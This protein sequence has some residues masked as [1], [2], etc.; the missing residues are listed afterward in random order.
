MNGAK[1]NYT[2]DQQDLDFSQRASAAAMVK[3]LLSA[4]GLDAVA[5]GFGVTQISSDNHTWV[6]SRLA[7]EFAQMPK[8]GDRL[9][10][11]TWVSDA[12][13]LLST[14]NFEVTDYSGEVVAQATSRW[15]MIDL[16]TRRPINLSTMEM[17]CVDEL[18]P[19][20][21]PRRI[22]SSLTQ[23]VTQHRAAYSDIDFNCHVNT[24]RYIDMMLDAMPFEHLQN[25][26]ISRLDIHFMRESKIGELLSIKRSGGV[27]EIIHEDGTVSIKAEITL[28]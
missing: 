22:D 1:Y 8:M 17:T 21:P 26:N 10:I 20:E 25:N 5:R 16:S 14:R 9:E 27:F 12:E 18:S 2:V 23:L 28:A 11:R 15:S 7:V 13:R 19:I 3:Y 24:L 6:L 4:A